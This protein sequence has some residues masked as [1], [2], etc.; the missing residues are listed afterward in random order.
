MKNNNNSVITPAY[1]HQGGIDVI[2]FMELK[3]STEENRG[4]YRGNC[5]KYLTRFQEKNGIEDLKKCKFYLNKLIELEEKNN[6][7]NYIRIEGKS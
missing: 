2:K 1:Y 6:E 7:D 3:A 5:F 4:F